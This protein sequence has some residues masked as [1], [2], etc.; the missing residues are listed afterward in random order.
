MR[1]KYKVGQHMDRSTRL[2]IAKLITER[3]SPSSKETLRF[4][5]LG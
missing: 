3:N 4:M 5:G 2:K 1:G